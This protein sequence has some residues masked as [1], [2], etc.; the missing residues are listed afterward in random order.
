MSDQPFTVDRRVTLKWL[1]GA[2]A[3]SGIPL[4]GAYAAAP[5]P[6]PE[7]APPPVPGPGYGTD[8]AL[9]EGK[10]PWP[11][12]LTAPQ[13][14]TAA[15]LCDTI[16]PAEG[17]YPAPSA[18]GIHQFI[19]EWVSAP[20]PEQTGDRTLLLAGFAWVEAEA[21][22]R[23]GKDYSTLDEDARAQILRDAAAASRKGASFLQRMKFLTTGAYYTSEQGVDQ[24][25]YVGNVALEGDYPG[26]TPEA[27]AHL[28]QVL[29]G[30]KLPA[31]A[32]RG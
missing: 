8:P 18:I 5:A 22:A 19:D 26:P 31:R 30:L 25:G 29:A 28:D 12:T 27:F 2:M 21:S 23:H 13:L 16:L 11:K 7:G 20:Y 3:A 24:L 1:F 14:R 15:A 6:W 17:S 4:Q 32:K 10:V 9:L